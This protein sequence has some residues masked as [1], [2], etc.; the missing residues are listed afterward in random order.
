MIKERD[1]KV[2]EI[3]TRDSIQEMNKSLERKSK[4]HFK[5]NEID[6]FTRKKIITT[7][8][9]KI[10]KYNT[11]SISSVD[12]KL[13]SI[14]EQS[15]VYF[16]LPEDLGCASPYSSDTSYV[17]VKLKNG[18]LI[19]FNHKGD[20]DCSNNSFLLISNLTESQKFRLKKSPIMSIRYSGTESYKDVG[21]IEYINF[22]IDK[23]SCIK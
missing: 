7:E 21:D 2:Q 23:L 10:K 15:F 9:Y 20:I 6:E 12:I 4:C 3:L 14:N 19:R 18:D 17:I 22:F 11:N 8:Y 5:K 1:R 13:Q 16:F